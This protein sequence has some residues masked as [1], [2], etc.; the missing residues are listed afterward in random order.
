[1][2]NVAPR[3]W[4]SNVPPNGRVARPPQQVNNDNMAGLAA[5]EP[6]IMIETTPEH[7]N[8][9]SGDPECLGWTRQPDDPGVVAR[10]THLLKNNGIASLEMVTPGQVD[11]AA[12]LFHRDG[13]VVVVDALTGER[14][15]ALKNATERVVDQILQ[16][17][18]DGGVVALPGA[19]EYQGLHADRIWTEPHDP[20]GGLTTPQIPVPAVTINFPMVELTT[21][22]G[23]IRQ[24]PGSQRWLDPIPNLAEEPGAMKLSTLVRVRAVAA[25]VRSRQAD[26]S[27]RRL[28]PWRAGSRRRLRSSKRSRTRSIPSSGDRRAKRCWITPRTGLVVA[29]LAE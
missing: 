16:V 20:I 13:F 7:R 1:M 8:L 9:I 19:I 29:A 26:L 21:G 28:R 10:R 14:F 18:P 12:E 23:P 15:E 6:G 2:N 22:N 25:T 3:G 24:I 5:P 11:R 27:L 4:F 17:D